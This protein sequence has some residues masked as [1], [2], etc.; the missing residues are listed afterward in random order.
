[1]RQKLLA[2]LAPLGGIGAYIPTGANVVLKPNFLRP[3]RVEKAVT[4]HP[5]LVRAVGALATEVGASEVTLTDS[6]GIGTAEHVGDRL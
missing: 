1:M 6:P 3:A 4:T 2:L 5:E